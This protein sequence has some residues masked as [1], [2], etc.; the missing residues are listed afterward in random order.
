M[1]QLRRRRPLRGIAVSGLGTPRDVQR[2]I[3]AGFER[4]VTKPI[5]ISDLLEFVEG[6]R[7]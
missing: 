5:G 2:C 7:A 3:A 1:R 4:H 6:R